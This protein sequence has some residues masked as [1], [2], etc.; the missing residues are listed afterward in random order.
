MITA[1]NEVLD[2]YRVQGV[3]ERYR[4]ELEYMAFYHEFLTSVTRVNLIEPRSDVQEKLRED[5]LTKFPEYRSNPYFRSAPAKYRLLA[6]LIQGR[7][8]R[9]VHLLMSANNR[10][11]GR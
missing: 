5:Y 9:G 11:K 10:V 2:Y 8:W 6:F 3:F 1:M 7:L 4:R